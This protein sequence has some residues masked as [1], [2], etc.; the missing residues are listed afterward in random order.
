MK[1]QLTLRTLNIR[2][3]PLRSSTQTLTYLDKNPTFAQYDSSLPVILGMCQCLKYK[4]YADFEGLDHRP[5]KEDVPFPPEQFFLRLLDRTF[6]E[7][8]YRPLNDKCCFEPHTVSLRSKTPR[9]KV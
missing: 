3:R 6:D 9:Q 2:A 5:A 4:D 7:A 8:G 1:D